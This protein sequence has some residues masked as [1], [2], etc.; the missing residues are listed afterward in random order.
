MGIK[1]TS[2]VLPSTL[3]VVLISHTLSRPQAYHFVNVCFWERG[4][5]RAQHVFKLKAN[6]QRPSAAL[7]AWHLIDPFYGYQLKVI[8]IA[9]LLYNK[10]YFVLPEEQLQ[11]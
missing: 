1:T 6:I 7:C 9:L 5:Y 10:T 2:E 8:E 3:N 11:W 4:E